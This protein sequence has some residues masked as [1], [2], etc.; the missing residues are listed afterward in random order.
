MN[1][2]IQQRDEKFCGSNSIWINAYTFMISLREGQVSN[3]IQRVDWLAQEQGK[4]C[5]SLGLGWGLAWRLRST[6]CSAMGA[7][8]VT[9]RG[10]LCL[11]F[12]M[13]EEG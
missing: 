4:E 3:G 5:L 7:Q 6:R 9:T 13:G 11:G 1:I 12:S 2:K 8:T 10:D